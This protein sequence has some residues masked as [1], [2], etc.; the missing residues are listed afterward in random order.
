MT[1]VAELQDMRAAL[2]KGLGSPTLTVTAGG[3]SRQFRSVAEIRSAI[4]TID[5][6]IKS[7][8]GGQRVSL[9]RINSSKGL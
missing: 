6:E 5:Q 3:V 2:V 7:A 1:A 9:I 8:G 4:A